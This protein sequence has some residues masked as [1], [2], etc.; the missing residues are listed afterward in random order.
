MIV[1]RPGD[2]TRVLAV[3][4]IEDYQ[5]V[6]GTADDIVNLV[7]RTKIVRPVTT[8]VVADRVLARRLGAEPNTEWFLVEG[9]RVMRGPRL[10]K[11]PLCWSE[12]YLRADSPGLEKLQRGDFTAAEAAAT[13]IEQTVSAAT[14]DERLATA[15]ETE[16]FSPALV[17]T[18]RRHDEQNR[19]RSVGVH[20]H[21]ADRYELKTIIRPTQLGNSG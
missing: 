3:A 7:A 14:L 9:P 4:P 18:R 20:T 15:L 16:P 10:D 11:P 21:P 5:P 12:Q 19:L 17:I 13:E 8:T 6:V 2:G 1:R